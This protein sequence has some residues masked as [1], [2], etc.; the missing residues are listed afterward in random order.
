MKLKLLMAPKQCG[1]IRQ[2]SP[3]GLTL[4]VGLS[5][6][7]IAANAVPSFA[8]QTGMSCT[9]C[10]TEFP[11]LTD[12]GRQFK[13]SGYTLGTGQTELPP[14]AFM[15]QPSFTHTEEKQDG[16]A[17]PHFRSNNNFAVDQVSAFYSGRLFGPYAEKLFGVPAASFLDKFGVFAQVT[18]DGVGKSFGWDNTEI[19][20]ADNATIWGQAMTYGIYTNNNP[21]MQDPWNTT[22][23]WGFP[24]GGS[25]L[26]PTPGAA[27]LIDG[28]LSQQVASL[29]A[30]TMIDNHVYLDVA[31]YHSLSSSFQRSMGVNPSGETELANIAPY[32]R[33][34]YTNSFGNSSAEVGIFGM[35]SDV[36]PGR[37]RSAGKDHVTDWG[38]DSQFQT[39]IDKHDVTAM[40]TGIYESND[41]GA[42]KA[43]GD[44]VRS[45][46]DLLT[47]RA[48][49]DYLYDKTIGVAVGYFITDGSHDTALYS[50]SVKGSPLSDGIV[51]Q[52]NYLPINKSGGPSFWP[53]S[54]IKLS[55]QY[56]IYNR[57]DGSSSNYNGM[58]GRASDNNTLYLQT[59]IAY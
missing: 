1:E 14:V 26:A 58:G 15:L 3:L 41:T 57:F 11:I 33:A 48:S 32:W 46:E 22:P 30:Y 34:A 16:G 6:L 19:R 42:S 39:S 2:L 36:Y 9:A 24:F 31:G 50:D 53:M 29:G 45:S 54:N 43:L 25:A 13:L 38:L 35:Y 59:W 20:Y 55:L 10:H 21:T 37:D 17:A 27:S 12:F 47:F 52:L 4:L 8:R 28:G 23:A 5:L 51:L 18:Y 56:V 44:A 49:V 40:L 7:P